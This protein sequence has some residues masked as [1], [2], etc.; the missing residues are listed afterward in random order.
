[1]WDVLKAADKYQV[2]SL[3]RRCFHFLLHKHSARKDGEHLCHVMELAHRLHQPAYRQTSFTLAK[4]RAV[5]IFSSKLCLQTLCYHCMLAFVRADDLTGV[6]ETL[7]HEAVLAW[8]R[9]ACA[10][11]QR[12]RQGVLFLS[13]IHI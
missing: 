5:D 10:Q 7:V 9:C 1:M 8:T 11:R 13:L 3:V 2:L 12:Q 4:A 6:D